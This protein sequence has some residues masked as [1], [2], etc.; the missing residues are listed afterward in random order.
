MKFRQ[1]LPDINRLSVV[2]ATIMMAFALTQLV[3][4]PTRSFSFLLFGVLLELSLNFGTVITL[5]TAVLA[6][7]GIDWL[8]RSHPERDQYQHRLM[9]IRHWIVPVLTTLVIG[10]ALNT[11]AGGAAWWAIFALGS[12]L[13]MAV[14]IAEYNVVSADDVLHPLAT[15]GLTGLSFALYLLLAYALYSAQLRLYIRIPLLA[16]GA[17]MVISRSFYLRLGRWHT[18]WAIVYSLMVSELA[19]GINY[20]PLTPTQYSVLLVG[21]AYALTS[22]LTAIKETRHGFAFWGEPV[23][24]LLFMIFI[25]IFGG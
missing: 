23:G 19:I 12:L 5:L 8:I 18:L 9:V 10:T 7:A 22:I 24:M 13:L 20:L 16:I 17:M 3:T 11:F 6:A 1:S 15:V 4:F 21:F 25:S 2:S 14:L